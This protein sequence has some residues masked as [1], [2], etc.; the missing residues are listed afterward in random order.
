MSFA[1]S[2]EEVNELV[3]KLAFSHIEILSYNKHRKDHLNIIAVFQFVISSSM[4]L[5][6]APF[7]KGGKGTLAERARCLG[8]DSPAQC[9]LD[10][11]CKV[12]CLSKYI[13]ES[14]EGE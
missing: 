8:L 1:R 5:Q 12:I 3:R 9:V 11:P 14:T 6:Y 4:C 2:L 10:S 7:K 13:Q